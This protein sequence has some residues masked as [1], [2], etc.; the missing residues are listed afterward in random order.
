[1]T[2][3]G[4]KRWIRIG[5]AVAAVG[6]AVVAS[7]AP[8]DAKGG[9]NGRGAENS[10]EVNLQILAINDFHGNIATSSGSFGGTG[11][12]D[13][14]SANIAA[15]EA[16]ADN[17]IMVS[18][19]DLIGASPLISALFHDEP[20]IEAMNLIGLDINGV[21]NHEFDEGPAG[22]RE[23]AGGSCDPSD[24]SPQKSSVHHIELRGHPN[25]I[26]RK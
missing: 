19:G 3:S 15:R 2:V 18:A 20:T 6:A 23:R 22:H 21:G 11:R 17:S 7:V 1:M 4:R 25:W 5:V 10:R 12:A 9:N 16:D 8:V 13:Y 14:L 26:T 24:E